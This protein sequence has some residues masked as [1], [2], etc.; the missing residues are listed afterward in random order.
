MSEY[1]VMGAAAVVGSFCG[2]FAASLLFPAVSL[3]ET[4]EQLARMK[5]QEEIN[6]LLCERVGRLEDFA[7][8]SEIEFK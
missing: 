5:C 6:R 3:A 4:K 1:I 7:R 2:Q 8:R